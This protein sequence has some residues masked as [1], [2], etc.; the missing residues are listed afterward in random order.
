VKRLAR[1]WEGL[2]ATLCSTYARELADT[3]GLS[4]MAGEMLADAPGFVQPAF[5]ASFCHATSQN[6]QDS[7]IG[8]FGGD[9][10]TQKGPWN[11]PP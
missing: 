1:R 6:P 2:R 10:S 3:L 9:D 4:V 5:E 11:L 7:S 8:W